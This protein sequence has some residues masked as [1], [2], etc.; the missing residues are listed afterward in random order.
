MLRN[1]HRPPAMS[2]AVHGIDTPIG[3]FQAKVMARIVSHAQEAPRHSRQERSPYRDG[4]LTVAPPG[5]GKTLVEAL[6]ANYAGIG[7]PVSD[8]IPARRTAVGIVH[9]K[10]LLRQFL[11]PDGDL[12]RFSGAGGRSIRIGGY[13]MDRRDGH[14]E[15]DLLLTTP[16]SYGS[17]EK[18]GAVRRDTT[19]RYILDE[20]H[21][22][23]LAP[24]MQE[25][26]TR[27]GSSL[28]MFTATPAIAYGRRDLRHRFPHSQFGTMR[29]FIEDGILSPVQLFTYRAG[30]EADSAKNIAISQAANLLRS[31]RKTLIVCQ[32]GENLK[33]AREIADAINALYGQGRIEL[34]PRF[35]KIEDE[36]IACAIGS[37]AS[38]RTTENIERVRDGRRLLIT[39]VATGNEGLNIVDLD[40]III[41]GPQGASWV[42]DQ[43][44]GRILR[45]S[46]Q[47]AIAIEILPRRLR[48][49]APLAS[50]FHSVDVPD[51]LIVAGHYVGPRN[52]EENLAEWMSQKELSTPKNLGRLTVGSRGPVKRPL[53]AP[54]PP[55]IPPADLD[56][57]LMDNVSIREATVAPADLAKLPP[58]DYKPLDIPL[59]E[60]VPE[61]WLYNILAKLPDS[62]I[63]YVGVWERDQNGKMGYV[64]YYSPAAH[65]Y[66]QNHPMPEL[67]GATE[68][69]DQGIA[70]MLGVS[71][72]RI[73]N[74][75]EELNIQPLP[76][77]TKSHRSPKYYGLDAIALISQE[78]EK[79]PRAEETDVAAIDLVKE[80]GIDNIYEFA[81]RYG[82]SLVDKHR[83]AVWGELG[84]CAHLN[85]IDAQ[86]VRDIYASVR[87]ADPK[88]YIGLVEIAYRAETSLSNVHNKLKAIDDDQ[89][90][91][92]E[93]MQGESGLRLGIYI[94]RKW[95]EAFIEYIKPEKILPWEVSLP[96]LAKYFGRQAQLLVKKLPAATARAPFVGVS[97]VLL[98][99]MS[100]IPDLVARGFPPVEG[101][102][103]VTHELAAMSS[104]HIND[105]A[106]IA[107]SQMVQSHFLPSQHIPSWEEIPY[108]QGRRI[109]PPAMPLPKLS[110]RPF[111]DGPHPKPER[112][113]GPVR[114]IRLKSKQTAKALVIPDDYVGLHQQLA[115]YHAPCA[116]TLIFRVA[117]ENRIGTKSW[118]ATNHGWW[119]PEQDILP[120]VK[121]IRGYE[122][123]PRDTGDPDHDVVSLYR[124]AAEYSGRQTNL[125]EGDVQKVALLIS[126]ERGLDREAFT[127]VFRFRNGDGSVG[128]LALHYTKR[129]ADLVRAKLKSLEASRSLDT[130]RC[131]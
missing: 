108:Y 5:A 77:I 36:K 89:K 98:Y 41:I 130:I 57:L 79:I 87:R 8:V 39:S 23:A 129:M 22:T 80:L 72:S 63:R 15:C 10:V 55:Y 112:V 9:S 117:S 21:R 131:W 115:H 53:E 85:R 119:V 20:A 124:I 102:P 62:A 49:G 94:E 26:V 61:E 47:L 52:D 11:D 106:R 29:E 42:V 37:D 51:R 104:E 44:L 111:K 78:I 18:A 92:I 13:Y 76:R 33:Q 99:P 113:T 19:V 81:D 50:I 25:N 73:Q 6:V 91:L 60:G 14:D 2:Q 110:R 71:R 28:Y 84:V 66:F 17:A 58:E 64:R 27:F 126:R 3:S 16:E 120:L 59:P 122:T 4:L 24:S 93:W 38:L 65:E 90:P 105:E 68:L 1:W 43:W 128:P 107:Y 7:L 97:P 32:P 96:M 54:H 56:C 46:G 35:D 75:I 34:H 118:L 88:R 12:Q 123:V 30:P 121:A 101:A 86:I 114:P 100:V 74:I 103:S 31:G 125:S 67:A 45:K 40:A 69:I 48:Q 116:P 127:R 70:D 83:N 109:S 95:G 82:I